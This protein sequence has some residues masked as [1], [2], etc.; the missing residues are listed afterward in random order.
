MAN[1]LPPAR[2]TVAVH[3]LM[4]LAACRAITTTTTTPCIAQPEASHA[5]PTCRTRSYSVPR[6]TPEFDTVTENDAR[7][8]PSLE[9]RSRDIYVCAFSRSIPSRQTVLG[10]TEG[11]L[12]PD[13]ELDCPS[14]HLG[15]KEKH[16]HLLSDDWSNYPVGLKNTHIYLI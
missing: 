6:D 13:L 14:T 4:R 16:T 8:H 9:T 5:A 11:F 2:W 7:P 1:A 10:T 3:N 15:L 12:V